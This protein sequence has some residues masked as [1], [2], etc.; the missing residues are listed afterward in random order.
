MRF[1]AVLLLLFLLPAAVSFGDRN[2][3]FI[4]EL[5][6]ESNIAFTEVSHARG[7]VLIRMENRNTG[8]VP[9]RRN[10]IDVSRYVAVPPD[11]LPTFEVVEGT[12][13]LATEDGTEGPLAIGEE[14]SLGPYTSGLLRGSGRVLD[15]F[16]GVGLCSFRFPVTETIVD[17][18]NR[19]RRGKAYISEALI[20][21]VWQP[22]PDEAVAANAEL[23]ERDAYL[24]RVAPSI[25][26]NPGQLDETISPDPPLPNLKSIDEWS[27]FL[28]ETSEKHALVMM[29]AP[30]S[31][32]YRVTPR[33]FAAAGIDSS[34][35]RVGHIRVMVRDR[36]VPVHSEGTRRSPFLGDAAF[37]FYVPPPDN[38]RRPYTPVW[39][40]ASDDEAPE[41]ET[42]PSASSLP[43]D[44]EGTA[45]TKVEI[46]DP[47]SYS[48]EYPFTARTGRWAT[49]PCRTG[50][51][52]SHEFYAWGIDPS[53]P[54]TLTAEF[55]GVSNNL[56]Q[57]AE[58]SLNGTQ[59][60]T[61]VQFSGRG[62]SNF[63]FD[64]PPDVLKDGK[65]VLSIRFP[66]KR[67]GRQS[68]E[69]AMA[70]AEL[71]CSVM[72][73]DIPL[74][75]PIVLGG[76]PDMMN[77]LSAA[78]ASATWELPVF[79][80]DITDPWNPAVLFA[81]KRGSENLS[82][83]IRVVLKEEP[84]TVVYAD[85]DT[86]RRPASLRAYE[87]RDLLAPEEGADLLIVADD[88]MITTLAPLVRLRERQGLRVATVGVQSVFDVFGHGAK[89]SEP[90]ADFFHHA[91]TAWPGR[92]LTGVLIVG[93]ASDY[94]WE[95]RYT[96][97]GIS[98]NMVPVYG[99]G[100]K[101]PDIRG[102]SRYS[103][104][105][106]NGDLADIEIGRI[107][108]ASAGELDGY[109]RK[110]LRYESAP[111]A[112]PWLTR[113]QFFT[114]D[115]QDFADVVERIVSL[116]LRSG[117]EAERYYLQD[118]PFEDYF[119][120][121]GRKRSPAMTKAIADALS[122]GALSATYMGHGGPNLWSAERIFHYRDMD[123]VSNEGR[124]PI[125]AAG[126]CDTAWIDYPN[127]I[128]TRSIG[129]RF[130]TVENSGCIA[131]FAPLAGTNPNEHD[132][133][134]RPF[135]K[136]IASPET[137]TIGTASLHSRLAYMLERNQ[138]YVPE[139]YVLLGD[140][141]IRIPRPTD[142][143]SL[144]IEN[145]VMYSGEETTVGLR[146][147]V[148]S[149]EWGIAEASV[150][151]SRGFVVAG[152]VRSHI[153]LNDFESSLTMPPYAPPGAY[154]LV[155]HAWN[156]V[157]GGHER[158]EYDFEIVD[159]GID[160]KWHVEPEPSIAVPA[161]TPTLLRLDAVLDTA[162]DLE[163][164]VLTV[165][166]VT[167]DQRLTTIPLA[168]T[169]GVPRVWEFQV[170]APPGLTVIEA[171]A[172][173]AHR[174]GREAIATARAEI[175][176]NTGGTRGFAANANLVT[177]EHPTPSR[178]GIVIP[179]RSMSDGRVSG[180]R[181]R[182][183]LRGGDEDAAIG[184][185]FDI[186][187]LKPGEQDSARFTTN[188]EYP[189]GVLPCDL[190]L[191]A[192]ADDG[193]TFSQTLPLDLNLTKRFDVAVVPGS[194]RTERRDHPRGETVFVRGQVTNV[195]NEI[196]R[197][198]TV[199]LFVDVP[200][201]PD[202]IATSLLES[203]ATVAI[204]PPFLPGETR[205]IRLRWD[206]PGN[207][208]M[209]AT[210]YMIANSDRAVAEGVYSNNSESIRIDFGRLPNLALD[211]LSVF[212]PSH[213][214]R[215]RDVVSMSV[216]VRN[217]SELEFPH[218]H[219]LRVVAEGKAHPP[220]TVYSE[221]LDPIA[222]GESVDVEVSWVADGLRTWMEAT[223]NAEMEFSEWDRN[224]N[225]DHVVFQYMIEP[226]ELASGNDWSFAPSFETG[227][228][229]S[230]VVVP[231]GIIALTEVP[232][233]STMLSFSNEYI[234]GA[235]L[236]ETRQNGPTD[237]RMM[238]IDG[239]LTWFPTEKPEPATFRLPLPDD[240]MTT[241]YDV[242]FSQLRDRR[243][244]GAVTN[245]YHWQVEDQTGEMVGTDRT[246]QLAWIG[247]FETEDDFLD[248]TF[249]RSGITS[250]NSILGIEVRPVA[251]RYSSPWLRTNGLAAC[252]F[253]ATDERPADT[254]IAYEYRVA[255]GDPT[256]PAFGEWTSVSSGDAI[257]ASK[258]AT[259]F[260]WRAMLVGGMEEIPSIHDVRL[261]FGTAED[262]QLAGGKE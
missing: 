115:E 203:R 23:L 79:P 158:I 242:S 193:T 139:Q 127:S 78:R 120:I 93:E 121:I 237:N 161:G 111:P 135:L 175:M 246:E 181:A 220:Q 226:K 29:K 4:D 57:S 151:N 159:P 31:G 168:L 223:V 149:I 155:V 140:P 261:V 62:P 7:E 72:R 202:R 24:R 49:L 213:Q 195:G 207:T 69:L 50:Q 119:R 94:W 35:M 240:D 183:R 147:S 18:A 125:M 92:R 68:E 164:V 86:A 214:I 224:D 137:R 192:S 97:P 16:R 129:E 47:A 189:P 10:K 3:E 133:L 190:V 83:D 169:P 256:E 165:R 134:L 239:G 98:E 248:V 166:D 64:V 80:L 22:Q 171:R 11:T 15:S 154:R 186:P 219:L 39:I 17:T 132:Y 148:P 236:P 208:P 66:E 122:R 89:D 215:K 178:T 2:E 71:E 56:S 116:S 222:P 260:Q 100:E 52:A 150:L 99:F 143:M 197:P 117:A 8:D 191:T 109:I 238:I 201:E 234:A 12:W 254:F 104:L 58:V 118:Y 32:V 19:N 114:D 124:F 145:G 36:E 88:R 45:T 253:V 205:D 259:V 136:S 144:E 25:V 198:V 257:P 53:H 105:S 70:W 112:G 42:L 210:L 170:P 230:T 21:V 82:V 95:E 247:R 142:R 146:G 9:E 245:S 188:E 138:A 81:S 184:A 228:H 241:I 46:L 250:Y 206:P 262:R 243:I 182:L 123:E 77:F 103:R 110:I 196:A 255:T 41:M 194:V 211:K 30:E 87:H 173:Y 153:E 218:R 51:L 33:D 28:R 40:F 128:V 20:K 141:F 221:Y 38:P 258:T 172:D 204:E 113:H 249:S 27:D 108:V 162:Y 216:T 76:E 180:I 101:I 75:A 225:S 6:Y 107:S 13:Y 252:R 63:F 60:G 217:D 233:I 91:W 177:L 179:V 48:H 61:A 157:A 160:L 232:R 74:D 209:E 37:S 43:P 199:A 1:R 90:I 152:P 229:E 244:D 227:N 163:D 231:P 67:D 5:L 235:R 131:L 34:D 102:D 65:N 251:G 106:G 26:L 85:A 73:T 176:G 54:A 200:W 126:S 167:S 187:E 96:R 14:S 44:P 55:G 156:S 130:V 174:A 212:P 84:I 59:L 185:P